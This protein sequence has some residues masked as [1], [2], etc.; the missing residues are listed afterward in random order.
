[1]K[2][3]KY[4]FISNLQTLCT[5]LF[6][7][8]MNFNLDVFHVMENYFITEVKVK[9]KRS[10]SFAKKSQNLGKTDTYLALDCAVFG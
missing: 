2:L 6:Y 5:N 7:F 10:R 9:V 4:I 8:G 3:K 1:M